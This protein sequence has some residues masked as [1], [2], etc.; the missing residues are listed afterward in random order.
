MFI[1]LQ[2]DRLKLIRFEIGLK[3]IDLVFSILANKE[4][5]QLAGPK[6]V[7]AKPGLLK[8][9]V[10]R[11]RRLV[12]TNRIQGDAN[13]ART[14]QHDLGVVVDVGLRKTE[15]AEIKMVAKVDDVRVAT[16]E[17]NR[18]GRFRIV[19]HVTKRCKK[20]YV[21]FTFIE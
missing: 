19:R 6:R 5:D 21:R 10:G 20:R 13:V 9:E 1:G 17:F 8:S 18:E 11:F 15:I 7:V 2:V 14:R 4:L 16:L 3:E 12:R